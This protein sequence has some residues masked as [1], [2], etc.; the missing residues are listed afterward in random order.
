MMSPLNDRPSRVP[1]PPILLVA[2]LCIALAVDRWLM[3][4]PIPFA[5]TRGFRALGGLALA[6]GVGLVVWA[7]IE[8][9]RAGTTM[10]PDHAAT[11]L[12]T[13]GPFAISRN[14]MY[15]GEVV[16]L[17]GAALL[18]NKLAL[19]LAAPVFAFAVKRLAI[20]GEEDHLRRRFGEAWE[21]Y[22]EHTN[23]W[24]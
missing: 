21:I 16:A 17:V 3:P 20:A 1:W 10:L 6:A 12:V 8:L 5:E 11:T 7:A 18:F 15:F 2:V 4:F 9:S 23:R 22:A 13:T 24:I 19:L 14:P